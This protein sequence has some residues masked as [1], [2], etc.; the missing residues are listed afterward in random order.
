MWGLYGGERGGIAIRSTV[1]A[2]K[3]ALNPATQP[4]K[5]GQISYLDW[6]VE[7]T[8]PNNVYGMLVRKANAYLHESEVRLLVWL[9]DAAERYPDSV[10]VTW[11][12]NR[13]ADEIRER[14]WSVSD[15]ELLRVCEDAI[16]SS[17]HRAYRAAMPAGIP[18]VIDVPTLIEEVVVGPDQPEWVTGVL[19]C[20]LQ[21]CGL[22]KPVRVS[23][24]R[25]PAGT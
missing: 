5:I 10:N 16:L 24:L 19:E 7:L 2:V 8:W 11:V 3:A 18:V 20:Y 25:H 12:A 15:G 6:P 17:I 4:V 13:M 1:G 14:H 9:P 23:A 21:R 22:Q